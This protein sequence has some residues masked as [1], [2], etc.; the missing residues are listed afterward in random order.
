MNAE[1]QVRWQNRDMSAAAIRHRLYASALTLIS[2]SYDADDLAQETFLHLWKIERLL[3]D[4]SDSDLR[5]YQVGV[6]RKMRNRGYFQLQS[7]HSWYVRS[8][9]NDD[10]SNRASVSEVRVW[11]ELHDL[12]QLLPPVLRKLSQPQVDALKQLWLEEID[13]LSMHPEEYRYIIHQKFLARERILELLGG[14]V[15]FRRSGRSRFQRPSAA[16]QLLEHFPDL[17]RYVSHKMDSINTTI[18]ILWG[19]LVP[20]WGFVYASST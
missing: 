11:Q 10:Y 9:L 2:A 12:Q 7:M 16:Q 6:L 19:L 15:A 8:A 13:A 4:M 5:R 3:D 17:D 1:R 18:D 20:L 14:E